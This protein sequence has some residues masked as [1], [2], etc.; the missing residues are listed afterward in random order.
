[1]EE[2]GQYCGTLG[3]IANCQAVVDSAH[4]VIVATWAT[5][6]TADKQQAVSMLEN[7]I[8]NTGAVPKEISADAGYYLAKTVAEL[9]ALGLARSSRR[10]RPDMAECRRQRP[11]SHTGQSVPQG[12]DAAEVADEN[13]VGSVMRW[14]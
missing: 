4:Q 9:Y 14:G 10:S 2:A 5:N 12:P 1:M 6:L 11:G 8:G 13:G 3:K 7:T